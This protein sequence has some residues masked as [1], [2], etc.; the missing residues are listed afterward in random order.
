MMLKSVS[1]EVTKILDTLSIPLRF[2]AN[3]TKILTSISARIGELSTPS[4]MPGYAWSL[5][6]ILCITGSKL[7][8]D[9]QSPCHHCY[10]MRGRYVMQPTVRAMADRLTGWLDDPD[11]SLL[12]AARLLLLQDRSCHFRWFDSGDLQG[13]SMLVDIFR[14]A[15]LTP[16]VSHWLPTQERKMV[17]D[18]KHLKPSNTLLPN[19]TIRISSP[20][21]SRTPLNRDFPTSSTGVVSPEGSYICPARKQGN[22]CGDCRA[23]WD[24]KVPHVHYPL[25]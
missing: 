9:V 11:W 12:M 25:H 20:R 10:A 3:T 21:L 22:Q 18:S 15:R 13:T 2:T 1:A 6:T 23:C 7:R 24:P 8:K 5:D 19:I 16:M 17:V 14:V 4:K